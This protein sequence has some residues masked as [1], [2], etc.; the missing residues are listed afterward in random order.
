MQSI[1]NAGAEFTDV[2]MPWNSQR[3]WKQDYYQKI[4][5]CSENLKEKPI[6]SYACVG[7]EKM[8]TNQAFNSRT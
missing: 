4:I 7:K 3:K 8:Q 1:L 5:K 6:T 2:A